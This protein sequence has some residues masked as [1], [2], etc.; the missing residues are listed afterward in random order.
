VADDEEVLGRDAIFDG[1]I[2][3][4]ADVHRCARATLRNVAQLRSRRCAPLRSD[5]KHASRRQHER[6]IDP[7]TR[8]VSSNNSG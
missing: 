3:A 2:V 4:R 7:D 1:D 5:E 6:E 8:V